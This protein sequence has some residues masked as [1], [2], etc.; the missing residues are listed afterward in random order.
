MPFV[1]SFPG[2]SQFL[3]RR[4]LHL[5]LKGPTAFRRIHG[6]FYSSQLGL[7]EPAFRCHLANLRVIEAHN[8]GNSSFTMGITQFADLTAAEFSAYVKRFPM[9]VTR[10]RNEVWIT[11]AP[12]QEVDWRQKNAVTEI[13]N[14]GQCGSCWSFSTTGSVEG[15]HAIATGKLVS[16]SEQQLMDCSTRYGN[17]GCNGGLMDYAFE[18]VIAN[19]GLDTEED[20]PYTAEDGK[21]N[22]EKEKKHA[23]EIHGF[24]NVPKEHEDQLAA[25]VSIGPVSVAIEADQAGFQHYTSGV[26]DGKCGTSLDHGV[27]V[28]GYSDDYWIVKNSWGKSWGEEGYIRLK[29]GVDK[30]G[31]CGI[32]MQASY[33]EKRPILC[34]SRFNR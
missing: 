7:C 3:P 9:N 20:Y 4:N 13:K 1:P 29:R 18:Y 26:F 22:T 15:A 25:A 11:E 33:P 21:C 12:L 34:F 2:C 6:V 23:A 5:V 8:A 24:R 19:G 27:L 28:V 30:K 14:Q 10:P 16:L 31:M 17:H 32:T